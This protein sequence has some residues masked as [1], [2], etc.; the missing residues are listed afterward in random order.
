MAIQ[1]LKLEDSLFQPLL[2]SIELP[3]VGSSGHHIGT[4]KPCAFA[5]KGLCNNGKQC[6]FCHLCGPN[7]KL[8]RKKAWKEQQ[9]ASYVPRISLS[10]EDSLFVPGTH[11]TFEKT[12]HH[13][14]V[15]LAPQY[16]IAPSWVQTLHAPMDRGSCTA[17]LHPSENVATP[18]LIPPLCE[19]ETKG[20]LTT[21]GSV[22]LDSEPKES[23]PCSSACSTADTE[24]ITG[25]V[26]SLN[27]A[28]GKCFL[29]SVELPTVGSC[30][31]HLGVCKPCAFG[32]KGC[33]KNGSS[34]QF[35]HLCGA[36]EIRNKKKPLKQR[37][38]SAEVGTVA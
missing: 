31:H 9:K 36:E 18:C 8:R 1:V 5:S 3:T 30:G 19:G 20:S 34:C 23:K 25:R 38:N 6:Q 21:L 4:C 26:L 33:C 17:K 14:T 27:D 10:L 16:V 32:F 13:S 15:S 2:G 7:E 11:V 22:T 24:D 12:T 37:R 28:H 29:G 35:C